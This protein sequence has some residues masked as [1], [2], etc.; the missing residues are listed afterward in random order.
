M[1]AYARSVRRLRPGYAQGDRHYTPGQIP[2]TRIREGNGH[3]TIREASTPF[4]TRIRA[5]RSVIPGIR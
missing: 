3:Y 2:G 1:G 5:G 4:A